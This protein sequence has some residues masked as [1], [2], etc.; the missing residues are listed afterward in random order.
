MLTSTVGS[1]IVHLPGEEF[2]SEEIRAKPFN[3][4]QA[5]TMQRM[6]VTADV[7]GIIKLIGECISYDVN[8]L[9]TSDFKY[10][11]HWFRINS[12]KD[13]P[14]YVEW[15]CPKCQHTNESAI[16]ADTLQ[17]IE[18]PSELTDGGL[19]MRF[20]NFE[21]GLFVRQQK[22]SDEKFAADIKK[23]NGI[24]EDNIEVTNIIMNLNLLRNPQNKLDI[25]ELW[26]M[27]KENKF[28]NDDM[29]ALD[30]F[31]EEYDW[32]VKDSYSLR[33][34]NC[35]EVVTV[36]SPFNITSF[37][38]FDRS[39]RDLR[40]RILPNVSAEPT[41]ELNREDGTEGVLMDVCQTLENLRRAEAE[42]G[43]GRRSTDDDGRG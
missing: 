11:L 32:G 43:A 5:K 9:F 23:Q 38:Q 33:C 10:L 26:K 35:N 13:F 21:E 3:V 34:K 28:T 31:R 16:T 1:E 27:Y 30:A 17:Y 18:V 6:S 14:R 29:A 20:D 15:D 7:N 25:E 19:R 24:S 22:I 12:Y 42:T 4:L 41:E 39:K 37:F 8:Q 2:Y 36:E 40:K